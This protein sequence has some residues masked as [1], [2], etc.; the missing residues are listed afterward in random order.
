MANQSEKI[1]EL[2]KAL[3][4]AQGKICGAIRDSENPFYHSSY[5]DLQS[6]WEACRD[7]LTSSGLAVI[8]LP[9]NDGELISVETVLAHSSGEWISSLVRARPAKADAQS[10][11]SVISYLRRYALAAMVGV[12]QVDDDGEAGVGRADS[13]SQ[14]APQAK[15]PSE[16]P[17]PDRS[18]HPRMA[19]T[20]APRLTLSGLWARA[21]QAG[22]DEAGWK[23]TLKKAGVSRDRA[24]HTTAA[25]S[26][27][28]GQIDAH[29]GVD[30]PDSAEIA[31]REAK[32]QQALTVLRD[33]LAGR[34]AGDVDVLRVCR[35][36]LSVERAKDV[37]VLSDLRLDE[38]ERIIEA[39]SQ[40]VS[41]EVSK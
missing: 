24:T 13:S 40:A 32:R 29:Q 31:Q 6:V 5:A 28:A 38:I 18:D 20:R 16:P 8:Q 17:P 22:I 11:G 39:V 37:S 3:A 30:V 12:Y 19:Q 1:G 10:I 2:A 36:H 25:L 27:I 14:R 41:Q 4:A 33:A 7:A 15:A 23:E 21:Q 26:W 35:D 34:C 9:G